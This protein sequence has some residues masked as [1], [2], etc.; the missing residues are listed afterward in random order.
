MKRFPFAP[1]PS[2]ER[3]L[4]QIERQVGLKFPPQRRETAWAVIHRTMQTEG[5]EDLPAYSQYLLSIPKAFDRLVEELTIGETY[6]FRNPRQFEVLHKDILPTL[7]EDNPHRRLRI[8]SAACA[9]GEEPYSLA[10]LLHEL[11]LLERAEILATDVSRE[12]LKRARIGRYRQW[13]LRDDYQA[14]TARYLKHDGAQYVLDPV[15]KGQVQ[16]AYH[17]LAGEQETD[18]ISGTPQWDLILCRNVLIYFDRETV[19][20]VADRLY[21]SLLPNGWLLLGAADPPLWEYAPF[22]T[23]ATN[24]GVIYRKTED[25]DRSLPQTSS[26]DPQPRKFHLWNEKPPHRTIRSEILSPRQTAGVEEVLHEANQAVAAGS[27]QRAVSLT[28][29]FA[30]HPIACGL[31]IRAL[32]NLDVTAATHLCAQFTETHPTSVELHYLHA[33]LLMDRKQIEPAIAA[34]RRALYLDRSL[35]IGHYTLGTLYQQQGNP[36]AA[37]RALENARSLCEIHPRTQ[38]IPL[39]DEETIGHLLEL[40][41]DKLQRLKA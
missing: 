23:V 27:Y 16:F 31:Q 7:A 30:D 24:E 34:I 40:I 10:I 25:E 26:A 18:V 38:S 20:R 4:K 14:W 19:T 28:A 15:I 11:N 35:V 21:R 5:Y 6:F 37:I 29:D 39:A 2:F 9:S 36:R 17:N 41:S 3:L 12:A 13:S 32:A 8:W 22:E 33:T 1:S